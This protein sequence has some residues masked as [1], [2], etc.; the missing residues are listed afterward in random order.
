[1]YIRLDV[2]ADMLG[3]RPRELRHAIRTGNGLDGLDLPAYRHVRGATVMFDHDEA[4][5]FSQKWHARI[6]SLTPPLLDKP[7]ISLNVFAK[8]ADV[9]PLA[10]RQAVCTGKRLNGILL[11]VAVKSATGALMFDPD[12]VEQFINKYRSTDSGK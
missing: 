2:F 6:T 9:A 3:V 7:L 4:I 5:S 11:P 8:K 10:L 12:A 1:M